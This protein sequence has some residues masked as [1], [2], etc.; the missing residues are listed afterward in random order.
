MN[1]Q[2]GTFQWVSPSL[3]SSL[4][5]QK[6]PWSG[7]GYQA[8]LTDLFLKKSINPLHQFGTTGI[9]TLAAASSYLEKM[10]SFSGTGNSAA[11]EG[12]SAQPLPLHKCPH[13]ESKDKPYPCELC[14]NQYSGLSSSVNSNKNS[15]HQSEANSGESPHDPKSLPLAHH[16]HHHHAH[17]Q[18]QA[19]SQSSLPSLAVH[20][21]GLHHPVRRDSSSSGTSSSIRPRNAN[22][23]HFVC[24]ACHRTFTQKGN[25]KTH[26][27]IHTGEKPYACQVSLGVT[28]RPI[29]S[30]IALYLYSNSF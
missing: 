12:H 15:N 16:H 8:S 4:S 5:S 6:N 7:V 23:K 25:L 21:Q 20:Q 14:I 30:I 13:P 29:S 10:S 18:G 1:M 9:S 26:M 11:N 17:L 28:K 27:M 19:S 22:S 3:S 2:N 24:P